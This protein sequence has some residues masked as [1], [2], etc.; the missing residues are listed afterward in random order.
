MWRAWDPLRR[1][2]VAKLPATH[3][4]RER[5]DVDP[6]DQLDFYEL[7][8]FGASYMLNKL[9]LE[10]WVIAAQLRH[11]HGGGLGAATPRPG[12]PPG[13]CATTTARAGCSSP[14]AI[15]P[16]RERSKGSVAPTP[17]RRSRGL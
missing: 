14:M 3:H 16:V 15:R 11:P 2:F 10:P 5:I 8:H 1:A 12:C 17:E 4:L 7:R 9:E 13:S 6:D